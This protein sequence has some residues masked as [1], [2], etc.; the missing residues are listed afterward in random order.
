MFKPRTL[1]FLAAYIAVFILLSLVVHIRPDY[2]DSPLGVALA[3]PYLSIYL[4]HSIGVPGLLQH[5][6]ACGWGWCAPSIFGWGFLCFFWSLITWL[7]AW[8]SASLTHGSTK[9]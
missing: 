4:F 8:A 2:A 5:N 7:F 1:K 3:I 6:G 9:D